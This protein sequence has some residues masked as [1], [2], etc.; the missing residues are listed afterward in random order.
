MT[1][2]PHGLSARAEYLI[3]GALLL[4]A[5][6]LRVVALG[7]VPHGLFRDELEKGYTALELW[8]TQRHGILG[9]DGVSVTRSFPVF[10]EVFA[11][12]DRTAALYQYLSA[13]IVGFGGLNTTTTRLVAALAGWAGVALVW[14]FARQLFGQWGGLMALAAAACQPTWI[15][16]SRWA[17]QGSLVAPF[18]LMGILLLGRIPA[19]HTSRQRP[20]AVLSGIAFGLAAYAYEP[21]RLVVP[22]IVAAALALWP[23]ESEKPERR[24]LAWLIGIFAAIWIPLFIYTLTVGSA[25]LA[26]VGTSSVFDVVA[27]YL[28]HW[29]PRFLFLEG[30]RNLRHRLPGSG[31]LAPVSGLLAMIAFVSGFRTRKRSLCFVL[32]WLAAAPLAAALTRDGIPHALRA[33]LLLPGFCLLAGAAGEWLSSF[34]KKWL[35][36]LVLAAVILIDGGG[37]L[38]G[39]HRLSRQQESAWDSGLL[40]LYRAALTR[41]GRIYLSGQIPYA[42]YVALFAEQVS[43]HLWHENGPEAFRA[44]ILQPGAS[45]YL[46]PGDTLI[47]PV[48]SLDPDRGD[49][50][51]FIARQREH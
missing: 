24:Y 18:F 27:N 8:E 20:M 51:S 3:A 45:P 17:Q 44:T 49:G 28:A 10:I 38:R 37:S 50:S 33:G 2:T 21:A 6:L 39:L 22:V 42:P 34:G 36:P 14:L 41:P 19:V 7:D 1:S 35:P 25:R 11:G 43:P 13:P 26:R 12:H 48:L 40:E 16:F 23:W 4:V 32:A 30:D 47:E 15:I 9:Q 5:L 31:L 46:A 29:N